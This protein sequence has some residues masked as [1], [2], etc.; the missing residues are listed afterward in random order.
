MLQLT[1]SEQSL[2]CVSLTTGRKIG[3]DQ[4]SFEWREAE[5]RD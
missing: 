1:P 3:T 4:G 5:G 2:L